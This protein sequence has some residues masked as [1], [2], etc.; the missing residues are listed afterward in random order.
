MHGQPTFSTTMHTPTLPPIEEHPLVRSP[1][2]TNAE[3]GIVPFE[4]L[5][6]SPVNQLPCD[7]WKNCT[8]TYQLT[9]Q[10]PNNELLSH[11]GRLHTSFMPGMS[12]AIFMTSNLQFD[13]DMT[14]EDVQ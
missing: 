7:T 9:V 6:V 4:D 8:L 13:Q 2:I 14:P 3:V 12:T 1:P 11:E 5:K 10:A